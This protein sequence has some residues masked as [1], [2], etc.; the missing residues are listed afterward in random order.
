VGLFGSVEAAAR[1]GDSLVARGIIDKYLIKGT[2]GCSDISRPRTVVRDQQYKSSFTSSFTA[3]G[4]N[5]AGRTL[6]PRSERRPGIDW[7]L[8]SVHPP[9]SDASLSPAGR[10]RKTILALAPGLDANL[11][12]RPDPVSMAL[13]DLSPG[14]SHHNG[15]LW[16]GGDLAA[17]R[18]RL[19]WIAGDRDK[20]ALRLESDGKVTIDSRALLGLSGADR[21]RAGAEFL[22]ADYIRSNEGLYLLAQLIGASHRYCFHVG[23]KLPTAGG[24]VP[25]PGS[26]NLDN[27]YDR[28]INPYRKDG[29]KVAKECPPAGFDSMIGINPTAVWFNIKAGQQVPD[30]MIAL[31]ELAE[32]LAKVEYGL[33]YLAYGLVPGAHDIAMQREFKLSGQRPGASVTTAGSN[34]VFCSEKSYLEFKAELREARIGR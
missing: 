33:E 27:N 1:Y 17:A 32:A 5:S 24:E 31:H 7:E 6:L 21:I 20:S 30:G 28:R 9:I 34:R 8:L 12:P 13:D 22:V 18:A 10:R 15:G 19:D 11:I 14:R 25:L 16:I 23:R 29:I 26:I 2:P 4:I 3:A